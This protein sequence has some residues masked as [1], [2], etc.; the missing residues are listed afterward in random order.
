MPLAAADAQPFNWALVAPI[1][2][3]FLAV[4]YLLPTP[5]RRPLYG[6]LFLLVLALAAFA[7]FLWGGFGRDV[8]FSVESLLFGAF[9]LMAI[10][11]AI[12]MIVQRN[13][14]R[15]AICF[16]VVI[17]SVCGLFLLLAAPFLMA[18]TIIIYAGAIIVTFLFV[19]MLSQQRGP[20][21]ANDR[22]REPSLAAGVGFVVLATLLVGLQRVYDTSDINS[23][24]ARAE[25]FAAA[26]LVDPALKDPAAAE[27]YLKEVEAARARLGFPTGEAP[28]HIEPVRKQ[29]LQLEEAIAELR[30]EAAAEGD[31]APERSRLLNAQIRDGLAY[32]KAVHD[33]TLNANTD[34]TL[35]PYS[36]ARGLP[37][38]DGSQLPDRLPAGNVAAVGRSL[39]ADHLIAVELGGTLL[40]VAT[41][42]AIAIAGGRRREEARP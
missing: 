31:L 28:R 34:I 20:S 13:P 4:W 38:A 29:V 5:R 11:F 14:A 1:L 12:L 17:L 30:Y 15:A 27:Q 33:G 39:Y 41:I 25:R 23:V 37:G 36:Q 2:T 9:S 40:L 22:S 26:N 6:G 24:I 19:I 21:D 32:L 8:P 10:L 7:I 42:G 35:S 3:G 16:A 18:A